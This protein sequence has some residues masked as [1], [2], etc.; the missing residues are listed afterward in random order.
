MISE[1]S[2]VLTNRFLC[3]GGEISLWGGIEDRIV[4]HP[5]YIDSNT[6]IGKPSPFDS[7]TE[8]SASSMCS[9]A[10]SLETRPLKIIDIELDIFFE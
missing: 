9:I 6:A 1:L 10:K 7:E 4:K 3:A 8:T 5:A 2:D